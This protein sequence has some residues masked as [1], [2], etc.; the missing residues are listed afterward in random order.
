MRTSIFTVSAI[1]AASVAF[2]GA[3][4]KATNRDVI[5]KF[6]TIVDGKQ[7]EKLPEVDAPNII[8]KTPMGTVNGIDGHKGLLQG[9]AGAFP[10]FKHTTSRCVESGELISCEGVFSGDHTGPLA[11]PDGS[12][13]PA[14]SKHVEFD[15]LG[16]ANVKSGKIMEL[17]VYFD[18]MGFMKQLGLIPPPAAAKTTAK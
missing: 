5:D 16:I 13:V 11:M 6:F 12:K 1:L 4:K 18:N 2:A 8:M 3:T 9:F 15:Y 17:H 10:N 14:T 7:F